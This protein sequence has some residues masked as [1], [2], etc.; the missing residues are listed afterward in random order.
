[1]AAPFFDAPTTAKQHHFKGTAKAALRTFALAAGRSRVPRDVVRR[2]LE[3]L[4]FDATAYASQVLQQF[5]LVKDRPD[6]YAPHLG[7]NAMVLQAAT[8]AA[9]QFLIGTVGPLAQDDYNGMVVE[10]FSVH[11]RRSVEAMYAVLVDAF[12]PTVVRDMQDAAQESVWYS[13]RPFE[14]RFPDPYNLPYVALMAGITCNFRLFRH[15]VV[16]HNPT[17]IEA[18]HVDLFTALGIVMSWNNPPFPP[19]IQTDEALLLQVANVL[20]ETRKYGL[21]KPFERN[22]ALEQ[23]TPHFRRTYLTM[24]VESPFMSYG[25]FDRE[26]PQS[27]AEDTELLRRMFLPLIEAERCV[28]MIRGMMEADME[29]GHWFVES[30]FKFEVIKRTAAYFIP[31]IRHDE[32]ISGKRPRA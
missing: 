23:R 6:V 27:L 30:R 11:S 9:S 24:L 1:M 21:L 12:D 4:I 8:M 16:E 7:K 32:M 14:I 10:C 26:L 17:W 2:T 3:F 28:P 18:H 29:Q 13:C 22:A 5:E 31:V 20:L 25:K 15:Q 19:H